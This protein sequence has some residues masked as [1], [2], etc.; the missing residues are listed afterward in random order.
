MNERLI[1]LI[2]TDLRAFPIKEQFICPLSFVSTNYLSSL[3][4]LRL[5]SKYFINSLS[6]EIDF[7]SSYETVELKTTVLE[8]HGQRSAHG[9]CG[10][11]EKHL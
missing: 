10:T 7:C 3:H 6:I 4:D 11:I 9:A 2:M 5:L 1:E 8:S